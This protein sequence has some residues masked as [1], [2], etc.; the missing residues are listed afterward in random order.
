MYA[1]TTVYDDMNAEQIESIAPTQIHRNVD[2]AIVNADAE[3]VSACISL[4]ST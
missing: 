3:G 2:L 4:E 1:G